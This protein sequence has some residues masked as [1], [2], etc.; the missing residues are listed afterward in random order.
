MELAIARLCLATTPAGKDL[1][2][3]H[4]PPASAVRR[5]LIAWA[6]FKSKTIFLPGRRLQPQCFGIGNSAAKTC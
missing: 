5:N 2:E 4:A 1:D 6:T 3:P